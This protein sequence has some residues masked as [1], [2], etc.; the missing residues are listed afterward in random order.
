MKLFSHAFLILPYLV[1]APAFATVIVS[2]PSNGESVNSNVQFVASANTTCSKGVSAMG[3]YVD[4]QLKYEVGAISLNT[5]LNLASGYHKTVV[6]EW[7]RCGG[8]TTTTI[9]LTVNNQVGVAV[10]S[11]VNGS[12]VSSPTSFVALAT[13]G[14]PA[15]V[16]ATGVYVNNQLI[17]KV[18]GNRLNAQL[19]L[20]GG[21]QSAV[22]QEWDHCGGAAKTPV[23]VNV[24]GDA[25]SGGGGSHVD[26]LQAN[27]AWRIWGELPP[28]YNVCSP[29]KGLSWSMQ[30][31]NGSVSLDGDSTQFNI[32]GT[33]PY[34]D[35][36]FYDDIM[37]DGSSGDLKD[38]NHSLLPTL[39][40]FSLDTYLYT[41]N[42]G[43]TQSLELDINMYMNGTGME[44]GTQCDHLGSGNWDIWNNV[45]AHWFSTGVPCQLNNAAWNHITIQVQRQAN[46]DL[47]YQ[48]IS[49]NGVTHT[50]N[51]TVAPFH[52]PGQ[53]WGVNV[54]Y[55]MDGNYR[56]SSNTTYMDKTT[57][58]YW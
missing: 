52:V 47:T 40:N 8:A 21:R 51:Q 43:V 41:P 20:G 45:T 16:A 17:Y 54:N 44:W 57:F 1:A 24:S 33:T 10:T 27:S 36:L 19:N 13:T 34:A 56:M 2:S 5:N 49:V 22:V 50:I 6:Q 42:L 3:I 15:G 39:H 31:H 35:V 30:Q 23:T 4:N 7:D 53:W 58:T 12:T 38:Q 37:G 9:N 32:G 29:C 48:T 25:S 46:N 28:N 11:P 14:C 55:Q 26:N 18:S